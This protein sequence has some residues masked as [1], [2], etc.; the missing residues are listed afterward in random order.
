MK[1]YAKTNFYFAGS[2][3]WAL[4]FLGSPNKATQFK[5]ELRF[6]PPNN[7]KDK[8]NPTVFRSSC[9]AVSEKDGLRFIPGKFFLINKNSLYKYC[10]EQDD[11]NYEVNI[12]EE[13]FHKTIEFM[14]NIGK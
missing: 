1:S 8:L 9:T 10:I 7:H 3:R 5:Y 14:R 13:I 12:E 6:T 4:Y 2:T 11:L